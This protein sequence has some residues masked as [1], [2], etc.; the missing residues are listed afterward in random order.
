MEVK[1]IKSRQMNL[2]LAKIIVIIVV[3]EQYV[4]VN[5]PCSIAEH[6][7]IPTYV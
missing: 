6:K 2:T 3:A 7:S 1:F 4:L 5:P